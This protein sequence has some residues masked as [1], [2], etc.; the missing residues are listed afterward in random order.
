MLNNYLLPLLEKQQVF[1][2]NA[3]R[4]FRSCDILTRLRSAV[5]TK[6]VESTPYRLYS[7]RG[8]KGRRARQ[9]ENANAYGGCFALC[10][11]GIIVCDTQ[12]REV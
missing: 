10:R 7:V 1:E 11:R 6:R 3:P 8:A 4:Y 2:P 9:S 5:V 12:R